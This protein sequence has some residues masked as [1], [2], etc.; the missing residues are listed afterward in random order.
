MK[1]ASI[2]ALICIALIIC[3]FMLTCLPAGADG[4]LWGDMDGNGKVEIID[5]LVLL[6]HVTAPPTET[7]I[8]SPVYN[9][10][11]FEGE[12]SAAIQNAINVCTEGGIVYIPAGTYQM[13]APVTLKSG[14]TI[15]GDGTKTVLLADESIC[16]SNPNGS[17]M[18]NGKFSFDPDVFVERDITIEGITFDGAR[19]DG[20]TGSLLGFTLAENIDIKNCTFKN[21]LRISLSLGGCKDVT[22]SGCTFEDNG[23]EKP[24]TISTP[25][26]W[27]DKLGDRY[28]QNIIVEDCLF[29]NN[30]W[31]GCYF[32]PIGGRI[33]RCTFIDNGE[34]TIFTNSNARDIEYIDNYITGARK[35][36]ISCSGI[37]IGGSNILVEGNF[38]ENCGAEGISLSNTEN[39]VVRNNM[40]LNN[41][42]QSTGS[43]GYGIF[44]YSL[45]GTAGDFEIDHN[46]VSPKNILIENNF[47]GNTDKFF[48]S[49]TDALG[50]WRN[51]DGML[52]ADMRFVNNT[53]SENANGE[54][55]CVGHGRNETLA[56]DCIFENN[57]ETEITPQMRRDFIEQLKERMNIDE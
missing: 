15:K 25:A 38:I 11:D 43:T 36:N 8:T 56:S 33:A 57:T 19:L 24:S 28:A 40:V 42:Q 29:R 16:I 35:S 20:R 55:H 5:V 3:T 9:V 13:T 48:V 26:L 51:T 23:L 14:I 41:G 47:F 30:N 18:Q 6:K 22:V 1:K 54:I 45:K 31:S 21:N 10:K 2:T 46:S 34:S 12:G 39:V 27:T 49:Q 44:M 52:I 4:A 50:A 53:L 7:P 37:E 32:M 17:L